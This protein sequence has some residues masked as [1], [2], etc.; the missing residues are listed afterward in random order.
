MRDRGYY[1]TGLGA[2]EIK[3]PLEDPLDRERFVDATTLYAP[4]K[5]NNYYQ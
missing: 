1:H 2:L 4:S 5:Q 3:L